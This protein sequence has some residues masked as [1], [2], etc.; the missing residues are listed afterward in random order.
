MDDEKAK[1]LLSLLPRRAYL[2]PYF[3]GT[4]DLSKG[5]LEGKFRRAKL[6][7][8]SWQGEVLGPKS[9]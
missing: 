5:L 1:A 9:P 6:E 8:A 4:L 2:P 7:L 3:V